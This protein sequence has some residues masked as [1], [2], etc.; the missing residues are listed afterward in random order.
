MSMNIER[1]VKAHHELYE[2]LASGEFE[3]AAVTKAFYDEYFAV[4]DLT[5]EFYLETV[6]LIFQDHA[7]PLGR[8]QWRGQPVDPNAIRRTR[9]FTVE[10]ERD[11]I[12]PVGQTVVADELCCELRPY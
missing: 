12:C 9:L 6:Q 11:D 4:L 1:H 7:L 2:H 5:A 10:A 8:L 3:K